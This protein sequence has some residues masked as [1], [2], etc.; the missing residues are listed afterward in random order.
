MFDDLTLLMQFFFDVL[1]QFWSLI[2]GS[3]LAFNVVL[4]LISWAVKL[5]KRVIL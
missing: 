5:I 3:I 2:I 1:T 4:W